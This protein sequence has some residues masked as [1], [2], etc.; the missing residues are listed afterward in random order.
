MILHVQYTA[1][2]GGETLREA[3]LSE[4]VV[5]EEPDAHDTREEFRVFSAKQHFSTAWQAFAASITPATAVATFALDDLGARLPSAPTGGSVVVETLVAVPVYTAAPATAAT[6]TLR[7]TA[8]STHEVAAGTPPTGVTPPPGATWFNVAEPGPVFPDD[9]A[10]S[11]RF[12]EAT[13]T[14]PSDIVIVVKTVRLVPL[15]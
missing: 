10:W 2:D 11:L 6:L 1:R 13:V 14:A 8:T 12:A 7:R 3:A 9:P 5:G 15:D 4:R